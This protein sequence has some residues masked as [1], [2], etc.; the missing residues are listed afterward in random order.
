MPLRS[1][2]GRRLGTLCLIDREPRELSGS[3]ITLLTD[4]GAW[5]ERELN[6]R[7][8][9]EASDAAE[10]SARQLRNVLDSATDAII[11]IDEGLKITTFNRSAEQMFG[12]RSDEQT[13]KTLCRLLPA[14]AI[15]HVRESMATLMVNHQLHMVLPR[16]LE[17]LSTDGTLFSAD[18]QISRA[19]IQQQT[20]FTL[21][22]RDVT[23]QRELDAMKSEFVATV[24][25]ELRTPATSIKGAVKLL[26]SMA[27]TLSGSQLKLLDIADKNCERLSQMIN[28]I[29]D[30][31]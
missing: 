11:S 3:E 27:N 15:R 9:Q 8:L 19:D 26:L 29:L 14:K 5:A 2:Q 30:L 16:D 13:D 1:R 28:D 10:Q 25:H 31:E 20:R 17:L 24:S 18:I 12:V 4:L 23:A 22:I 7:E 6:L 21:I